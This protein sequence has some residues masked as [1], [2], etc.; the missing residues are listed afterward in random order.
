MTY[1]ISLIEAR[2]Y[3]ELALFLGACVL[4]AIAL[5]PAAAA[6]KQPERGRVLALPE[7]G[8][9]AVASEATAD[10]QRTDI[11]AHQG[12]HSSTARAFG[13]SPETVRRIRAAA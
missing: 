11:R 6:G 1:L 8:V 12:S 5:T 4:N 9:T 10:S 2:A 7:A 3:G 13:T